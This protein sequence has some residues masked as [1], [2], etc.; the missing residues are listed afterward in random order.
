M[1]SGL[2]V[3]CSNKGPMPEVLGDAGI[4]FDPESP[5]EIAAAIRQYL[6]STEL[7]TAHA[8]ASYQRAKQYSWARCANE[9]FSFL[10]AM[11]KERKH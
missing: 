4:Y 8:L 2:P 6:D 7:R 5:V 3:A 1:V 10:A 9:T 11:A